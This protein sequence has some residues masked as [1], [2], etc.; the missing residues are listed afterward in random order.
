LA[1]SYDP[2]YAYEDHQTR[3]AGM[4][5][6]LMLV[7]AVAFGAFV[8]QLYSAPEV[9]RIAAQPGPYKIQP[10]TEAVTTPDQVEQGAFNDSL[11]G[12]TEAEAV[13][14]RPGPE[15]ARV[16]TEV[17]MPTAAPTSPTPGELGQMPRFVANGPYVAQL[18]A[19]QSE[20]AV[21]QA[22]RRLSSRAPELFANARMDV[23]RADLGQRGV[24]HRVRAGYFADRANATL[25]C[26]R[27]RQMG[28]DCIVVAR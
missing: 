16:E 7:V 12:R 15:T 4:L 22:W 5:Y 14:P 26:D 20:P 18:A 23:Q 13:T 19:L 3:H 24:Y 25:F 11:E 6:L 1:R 28:Q 2:R 27:I 10:S 9:P 8:W 21:E 17:P